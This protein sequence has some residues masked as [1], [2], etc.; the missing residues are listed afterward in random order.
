MTKTQIIINYLANSRHLTKTEKAF[1]AV[2]A[3]AIFLALCSR[4]QG[5]M[6][7]DDKFTTWLACDYEIDGAQKAIFQFDSNCNFSKIFYIGYK[8]RILLTRILDF[9]K[10]SLDFYR[11]TCLEY[12]RKM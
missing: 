6:D 12:M 4:E 5:I 1:A 10:S 11:Q 2:C 8:A 7:H 9:N 3:D